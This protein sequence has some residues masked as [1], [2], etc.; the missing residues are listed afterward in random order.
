MKFKSTL[1][2]GYKNI[3]LQKH[4]WFDADGKWITIA[5]TD[6]QIKKNQKKIKTESGSK[7]DLQW[8]NYIFLNRFHTEKAHTHQTILDRHLTK[9]NRTQG[10]HTAICISY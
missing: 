2:S 9:E 4:L 1:F 6:D 8:Y 7:S 5:T 3:K 10:F